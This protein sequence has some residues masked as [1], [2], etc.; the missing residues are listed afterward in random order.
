M[1]ASIALGV[2][3]EPFDRALD[4]ARARVAVTKGIDGTRFNAEE[5]KRKVPDS[6]VP[7]EELKAVVQ[8]FKAIVK[9]ASFGG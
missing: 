6:D 8:A 1:H 7:A 9:K 4:E 3:K 5:L 2:S